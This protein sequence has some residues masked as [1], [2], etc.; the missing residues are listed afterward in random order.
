M[1]KQRRKHILIN[2]IHT[3]TGGGLVYLNNI[4]IQF[5][6]LSEYYKLTILVDKEYEYK[7]AVPE[8]VEIKSYNVPQ[9]F[10]KMHVWEQFVLPLYLVR[11]KYD[12]LICNANYVPI[13]AK[14]T[15]P[16]IHNNPAVGLLD[17]RI[18]NILYWKFLVFM[19][20]FS[21][22]FSKKAFIVANHVIPQYTSGLF[23]FLKRKLIVAHPGCSCDSL[24]VANT[25]SGFISIGDFYIQKNYEFLL[26]AYTQYKNKNKLYEK[27]TIVGNVVDEKVY[28]NI[29]KL[30]NKR[31]LVDD[32]E[33][34][35]GM[36]HESVLTRINN[37]MA[38]LSTSS[39]ECFNMPILEA[40]SLGTAVI[41]ADHQFQ[42]EVG[43]SAIV[44]F[45]WTNDKVED[46]ASLV[47]SMEDVSLDGAL[48]KG[49]ESS[50]LERAKMFSWHETLNAIEKGIQ[51]VL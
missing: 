31:G 21:I 44:Y 10:L 32:I 30:I 22:I 27:L 7:I 42:K 29:L 4:L 20:R 37:S 47:S 39:V 28:K 2:A 19:T 3:K 9:S 25:K 16:I 13:L 43:G 11:L 35:K 46:L 14:R 45:K 26:D 50:G 34:I 6:K 48:R 12:L 40:M 51:E 18:K 1:S 17:K 8:G 15:I 49:Y 5:S 36:S 38:L 33:I 24:G 41:S 23:S